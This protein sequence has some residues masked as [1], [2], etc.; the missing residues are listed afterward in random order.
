VLLSVLTIAS[1][2]QTGDSEDEFAEIK[3]REKLIEKGISLIVESRVKAIE[4]SGKAIKVRTAS[5]SVET[6]SVLLGL[7]VRPN[8]TLAKSAGINIG[9]TGAIMDESKSSKNI[10]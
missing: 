4:K 10:Q 5:E 8:T 1:I 9:E 7:G 2:C 3:I 6:E